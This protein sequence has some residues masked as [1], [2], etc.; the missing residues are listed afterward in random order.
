MNAGGSCEEAAELATDALQTVRRTGDAELTAAVQAAV[1]YPC[2]HAGRVREV[3]D[4]A[5]A[6]LEL[7]A[8]RPELSA[9][10]MFESPRGFAFLWRFLALAML[11]RSGEALV[12][13]D[14]VYAFLRERRH[15]ET[16][17]WAAYFR[18]LT[19]RAAGAEKM[20][21]TE[22]PIAREA[23]E[24]AEAIAGPWVKLLAQISLG[25]AYLG[26]GRL[27]EALE[28]T[29]R[30][31]TLMET[32]HGGLEALVRP[33][34][35]LALTGTGDPLAGMAEAARAIRRCVECGNRQLRPLSCAAF[36]TATAAAATGLGRASE[37]LD[38]GE[39][40]VAETGARGFLPELLYG[41]ALLQAAAGDQ[42]ARRDTLRRGVTVAGQ[43][44]AHG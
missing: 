17:S 15:K 7:T 19:L 24:I 30:A 5:D 37:I 6:A 28:I 1:A 31:V 41:R 3:L 26:A 32:S 9:G 23:H 40:M 42:D 44:G 16:L 39:R 25:A 8:D 27:A 2:L 22:V 11:G 43:N 29:S 14:E 12:A 21:E 36:A 18:L 34:H 10:F 38:D 13:M 4:A 20:D 35:S 33:E